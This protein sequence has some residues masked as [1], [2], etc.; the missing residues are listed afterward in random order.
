MPLIIAVTVIIQAFF[1][2]HVF[3]NNRPYWWAFLILSTPIMGCLIYYFVEVFPY[4]KEHRAAQRTGRNLLRALNPDAAMQRR[5]DEAEI[6]G[7]V[8][9]KSALAEECLAAGFTAD[10]IR[11]FQSSLSGAHADDPL[12]MFGLARAY[13]SHGSIPQA[14]AQLQQLQAEHPNFKPLEVRLLQARALEQG[15]DPRLALAAYEELIP[16]YTGLEAKCR[17]ALLL[18]NAGH[19]KQADSLFQE[20]LTH[21]K[22]FNVN[23]ESEQEWVAI[24]RQGGLPQSAYTAKPT[25]S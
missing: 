13:L 11:L 18:Q 4:S 20:I 1:I 15:E 14:L 5:I 21:S 16:L 25:I 2:Y 3:R 9:N 19:L 22:R 23:L 24:A 8:A 17:Y 6:C 7:S 12:L 10:A